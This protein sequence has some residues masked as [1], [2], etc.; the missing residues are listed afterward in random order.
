MPNFKFMNNFNN[1]CFYCNLMD[2]N[3][4]GP[5]FT[6]RNGKERLDWVLANFNW[7]ACYKDTSVTHLNWF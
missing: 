7:F 6:W 1:V 3:V 2:L 4:Y 5:R